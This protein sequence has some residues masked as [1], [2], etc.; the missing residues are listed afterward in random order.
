MLTFQVGRHLAQQLQ[1]LADDLRLEGAEASDVGAGPRQVRHIARADR[2]AD[3]HE[4]HGEAGAG[5]AQ[6]VHPGRAVD[7]NDVDLAVRMRLGG[8]LSQLEAAAIPAHVDR[9]IP[10]IGPAR[11]RK[12]DAEGLDP[13]Q[14]LGIALGD[15]HHQADALWRAGRG[16]RPGATVGAAA[17]SAAAPR[18]EIREATSWRRFTVRFIMKRSLGMAMILTP[19]NSVNGDLFH[20]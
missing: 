12:G 3:H 20:T 19:A 13:A 6:G 18:D 11:I 9:H 5:G 16:L 14:A 1:P 7:D 2:I 4:H 17:D 10:P 15:G 8:G